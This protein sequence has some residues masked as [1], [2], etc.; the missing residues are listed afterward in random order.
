MLLVSSK[1]MD[2]IPV[3]E[4]HFLWENRC[5]YQIEKLKFY[6]YDFRDNLQ[7]YFPNDIEMKHFTLLPLYVFNLHFTI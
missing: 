2:L 6:F 5:D 3:D 4:S 1:R 7:S